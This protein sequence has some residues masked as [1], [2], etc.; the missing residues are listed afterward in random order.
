MNTDKLRQ[1]LV[2]NMTRLFAVL[3]GASVPDLPTRLYEAQIPNHCLFT[4]DLD[5]N[6]A[7]VAPYLVYLPPDIQF[8]EWVLEEGF[9]AHWGIFAHSRASMIEMRKHF[10]SLLNV[11]DENANSLTFRFYDPRVISKFL[12]TCTAEELATFFGKVDTFFAEDDVGENLLSFQMENCV[13]KQT[14]LS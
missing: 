7:Y 6:L 5:P 12:P 13:L 11:Y 2:S 9:G 14:E 1:Y 10:R 3:D 8:T 4:G